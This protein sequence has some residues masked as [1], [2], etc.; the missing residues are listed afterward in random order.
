MIA[1]KTTT[2]SNNP[3]T[4]T[5]P[6]SLYCTI[7]FDY[8]LKKTQK[9]QRE[10]TVSGN[11][12]TCSFSGLNWWLSTFDWKVCR[13]NDDAHAQRAWC[14]HFKMHLECKVGTSGRFKE[15]WEDNFCLTFECDLKLF[16]F[17][18]APSASEPGETFQIE[19]FLQGQH[20]WDYFG[21]WWDACY[22]SSLF[23]RKYRKRCI[24]KDLNRDLMLQQ[25]LYYHQ[26]CPLNV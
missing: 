8:C 11:F 25:I 1:L 7:Y 22:L 20:L 15:F 6:L 26:W 2:V 5:R 18:V 14:W 21:K 4:H 23:R 17:C 10:S 3:P 19:G 16:T 12:L 9:C 13:Q 24:L